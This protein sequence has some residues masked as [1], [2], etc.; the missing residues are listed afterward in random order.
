M[1]NSLTGSIHENYDLLLQYP[2]LRIVGEQK[3]RIVHNLIALKGAGLGDIRRVFSHPQALAQCARFLD[4]HAEWERVAFYDTAGAVQH[5]AKTG[6]KENAAIAS[7]DAARVYGLSVLR[8]G[9]ETNVQNYTRFFVI[10]RE[11]QAL[12]PEAGSRRPGKASLCFAV[13]DQPGALFKALE[14]LA[15]RGLNMKKLES[16]PIHGKPWEYLFYIDVDLPQDVNVFTQG[17]EEL[18][19]VSEDLRILG[20][21]AGS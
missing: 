14:V 4:T 2:D 7:E 13:A 12:P 5:V 15:D 3:I 6:A 21:Y 1:E 16:R 9:L 11:E 19:A 8:Q 17:M 18:K 10:A 20:T